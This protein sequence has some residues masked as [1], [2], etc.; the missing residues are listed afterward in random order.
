MKRIAIGRRWRLPRGR[1][2]VN[3]H[4]TGDK[5]KK[6]VTYRIIQAE[7]RLA[8]ESNFF[9][10][11]QMTPSQFEYTHS[12][13]VPYIQPGKTNFRHEIATDKN[14]SFYFKLS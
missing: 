3:K 5:R 2:S 14:I 8:N 12:K 1:K 11:V 9:K 7:S 4:N 10:F 6:C 13:I